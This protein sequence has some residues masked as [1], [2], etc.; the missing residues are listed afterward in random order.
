MSWFERM[1]GRFE[2]RRK[3]VKM[4]KSWH[5]HASQFSLVLFRHK[6]YSLLKNHPNVQVHMSWT[7]GHRGVLGT[8]L[9]DK[10]AK[11]GSKNK[12]RSEALVSLGARAP[13]NGSEHLRN[14]EGRGTIYL[15]HFCQ[16]HFMPIL[17]VTWPCTQHFP[18]G[19][20]SCTFVM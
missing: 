4:W 13:G 20:I 15:A 10:N 17:N 1:F 3:W 8:A 7:P 5:P 18:T 19:N 11:R 12:S 9:A 6:I 2:L 16:A 14:I